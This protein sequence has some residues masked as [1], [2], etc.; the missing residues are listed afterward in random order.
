MLLGKKDGKIC[1]ANRCREFLEYA[2]GAFDCYWLTTHCQ[3]DT[4]GV[5]GYLAQFADEPTME[6]MRKIKPTSF[7][8]KT[9]A[10]SGDFLWMD[11]SPTAGEIS[12]LEK[13]GWLK[14]W[15]QIDSRKNMDALYGLIPL[16][17]KIRTEGFDD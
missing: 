7:S 6:L 11:D 5:L 16:L 15:L 4:E 10:L 14:R 1:L 8:W 3:G 12:V 9:D 13:K 2:I 17:E